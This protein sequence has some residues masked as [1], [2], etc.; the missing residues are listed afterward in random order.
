MPYDLEHAAVLTQ[1]G[2]HAAAVLGFLVALRLDIKVVLP[3]RLLYRAAADDLHIKAVRADNIY[4]A[5]KSAR[6]V[7]QYEHQ[8]EAAAV[9]VI[10]VDIR[11]TRKYGEAGRVV[12]AL[13]DIM[14]EH[15][16][17]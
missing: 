17:P 13:V 11:G 3:C 7:L 8:Q 1:L 5:R 6:H 14:I 10:L 12:S 4:R 9:A 16:K 15:L 2:Y